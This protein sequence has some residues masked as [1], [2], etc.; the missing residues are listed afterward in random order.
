MQD[1]V[2]VG[3]VDRPADRH[4]QPG[5]VLRRQR[6]VGQLPRQ[7]GPL[8]VLHGEVRLPVALADLKDR[9]DVGV[10]EPRRRLRLD[11]KPLDVLRRR[12]RPTQRAA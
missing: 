9:H 6:A 7:G 8:D 10:R 2:V 11:P 12:C 1:A 3:V 4:Q 5:R